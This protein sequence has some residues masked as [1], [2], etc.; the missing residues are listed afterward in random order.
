MV[1]SVPASRTWTY[2]AGDRIDAHHDAAGHEV[3]RV[4]G[5]GEREVGL[6]P[7]GRAERRV[8]GAWG[9]TDCHAT[10]TEERTR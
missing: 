2:V 8:G 6:E 9:R 10:I 1:L 5:Q 3:E 7:S 4:D